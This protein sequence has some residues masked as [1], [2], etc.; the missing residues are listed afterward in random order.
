MIYY[1][2]MRHEIG[3]EKETGRFMGDMERGIEEGCFLPRVEDEGQRYG[4]NKDTAINHTYINSGSYRRKFDF[5]SNSPDL[6]RL[7]FQLSKKMLE[8]R[9][10][11]KFED[12]YWIDAA[13]RRVI[14]KETESCSEEQIVYSN[15]IR[16]KISKYENLITLHSH[17]N[18]YPPSINDL[19]SNFINH[20]GLGIVACH[21]GKIFKYASNQEI[22]EDYY[23]MVVE[24]YLK[25]GY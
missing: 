4:R 11:T 5:I 12:M 9:S 22:R 7:I 15:S 17:P 23:K 6:N 18:S 2:K 20:Y 14:A 13:H 3:R 25:K 10:G 19:N 1:N 8:H 21:D 24:K 16:S